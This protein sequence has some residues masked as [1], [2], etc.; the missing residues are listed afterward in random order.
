VYL[1]ASDTGRSVY[2]KLG[3]AEYPRYMERRL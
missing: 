1:H 3:F 2:E